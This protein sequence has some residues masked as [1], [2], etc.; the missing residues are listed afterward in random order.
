MASKQRNG[1]AQA[2]D[3]TA[4]GDSETNVQVIVRC[5]CVEVIEIIIVKV[6]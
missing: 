6:T 3:P 4:G 1:K 5:R 2:N